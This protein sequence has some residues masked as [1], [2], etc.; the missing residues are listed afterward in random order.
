MNYLN[1]YACDS[2]QKRFLNN[3]KCISPP[4]F[5]NGFGVDLATNTITTCIDTNCVRCVDNYQICTE[6]DQAN[7]YIL[8]NGSCAMPVILI[9]KQSFQT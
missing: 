4:E 9:T 7:G 3:T 6:C 5:S 1:C 8:V 2:A